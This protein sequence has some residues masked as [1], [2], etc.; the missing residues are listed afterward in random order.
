M[1]SVLIAQYT[2]RDLGTAKRRNIESVNGIPA[3]RKRSM[4]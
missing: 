3:I 2:R 1:T 4:P